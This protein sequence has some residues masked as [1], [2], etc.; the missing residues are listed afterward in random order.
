MEV[1]GYT[2]VYGANFNTTIFIIAPIKYKE[3]PKVNN[4]KNNLI[5]FEPRWFVDFLKNNP[6]SEP[7]IV[8]SKI[9]KIVLIMLIDTYCNGT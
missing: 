6:P 8:I 3:A 7:I 9:N 2:N 1:N 4:P 5:F